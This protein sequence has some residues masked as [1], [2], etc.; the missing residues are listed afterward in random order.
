M[1]EEIGGEVEESSQEA[2]WRA[3]HLVKEAVLRQMLQHT[4]AK[5]TQCSGDDLIVL[6]EEE[7]KT[8]QALLDA[9]ETGANERPSIV[10]A[11]TTAPSGFCD[12]SHD[13]LIEGDDPKRSHHGGDHVEDEQE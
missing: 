2:A 10:R 5:H 8:L 6:A 13:T 12:A 9:T 4:L 3:S 1:E 7:L 11:P